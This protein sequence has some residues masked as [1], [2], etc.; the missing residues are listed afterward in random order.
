[1]YAGHFAAG[2]A[3]KGKVPEAPTWALLLGVTFLDLLFGPLVLLGVEHLTPT[4]GVSPGFRLDFIDWS[5]S[6]AMAVV[7]SLLAGALFLKKG[8]TVAAAV[9]IAVF[10][11]FA[12]DFPMHPG[13]LAL[14]PHSVEHL[15]L[16]LWKVLPTGWWFV[17][18][19]FVVPALGYYVMRARKL[20]TFGGRAEIACAVVLVLHVTNSP[21]LAPK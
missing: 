4:P 13:D 17:E 12:L 14:Y 15:G 18:L 19:A 7:W 2:L 5:H 1:M 3:L 9:A 16:G 20:G 6:L 8:R 10:S 21:W 11:H